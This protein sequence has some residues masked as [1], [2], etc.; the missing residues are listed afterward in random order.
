[1]KTTSVI[2]ASVSVMIIAYFCHPGQKAYTQGSLNTY[3]SLDTLVVDREIKLITSK[4]TN[5]VIF[6][7]WYNGED[8]SYRYELGSGDRIDYSKDDKSI[9]I[10]VF[11]DKQLL[12]IFKIFKNTSSSSYV[13]VN[14]IV[15]QKEYNDYDKSGYY[16][17]YCRGKKAA[18]G[19]V[20]IRDFPERYSIIGRWCCYG[21]TTNHADTVYYD[22][23][24]PLSYIPYI[25]EDNYSMSL[26]KNEI[27]YALDEK[28]ER[29]EYFYEV[30]EGCL[31]FDYSREFRYV[32]YNGEPFF[33]LIEV[34]KGI[35]ESVP[36]KGTLVNYYDNGSI[37][38]IGEILYGGSPQ[39]G[40]YIEK[41]ER[42]RFEEGLAE[43]PFGID[44]FIEDGQLKALTYHVGDTPVVRYVLR[45]KGFEKIYLF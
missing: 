9:R 21:G 20:L 28:K 11:R 44:Y 17:Y 24:F 27:S 19:R 7:N 23:P 13:V 22:T 30:Y 8:D 5:E 26:P 4:N 34:E 40:D 16:T 3:G 15:A 14:D 29:L 41:G 43:R 18:E 32:L 38:S 35:R 33:G 39:L 45:E 42:K 6:F 10:R 12:H 1:M 25:Y 37:M 31:T 36:Y 2:I